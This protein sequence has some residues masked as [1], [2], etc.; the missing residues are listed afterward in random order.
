MH[1]ECSED[2]QSYLTALK[3]DLLKDPP[4]DLPQEH[5]A[6]N[7]PAAAVDPATAA[8]LN[9][10]AATDAPDRPILRRG[11]VT[12][13]D[14]D[15]STDTASTAP[16]PAPSKP[17]PA[18]KPAEKKD[19]DDFTIT[20]DAPVKAAPGDDALIVRTKEWAQTFNQGLPNFLCEQI[21]TRSYEQSRSAGWTAADVV[22]AKVLYDNGHEEYKDI[23]VGGKR[24]SKSMMEIGGST[25]T[26]EFASTLLSLLDGNRAQFKFYQSTHLANQ[27]ASIYDFKVTLP[28]S[29]WTII[30]GSQALMPAYSGSVWIDKNSAQIRRIEMQADNI[31][32]DFPDDSIQMAVDYEPVRLGAS[33]YLLPVHAENLACQRGS[34]ICSKN[35]IDFR[36]YH[37]YAGESTIE[38]K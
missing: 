22:T 4:A 8:E 29:D 31:P 19:S 25:S 17:K 20:A 27:P 35:E 38:Y 5:A 12:Q 3:V 23:T 36:N 18:P 26:G 30:V 33:M 24:T 21:T 11:H 37:K 1:V 2:D 34:S 6:A 15:D 32:K 16:A 14:S 9:K 7:R 13:R 28:A 10:P